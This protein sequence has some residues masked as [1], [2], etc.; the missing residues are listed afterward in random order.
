MKKTADL[1]LPITIVML[2]VS[3]CS[4]CGKLYLLWEQNHCIDR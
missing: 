4:H 3:G 2:F 1:V